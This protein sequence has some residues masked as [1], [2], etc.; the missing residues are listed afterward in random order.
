MPWVQHPLPG[1]HSVMAY[2]GTSPVNLGNHPRLNG[3]QTTGESE[4]NEYKKSLWISFN[5]KSTFILGL[6]MSTGRKPSS[7]SD[8]I[9]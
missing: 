4:Q 2:Q 5:A 6:E 1:P 7:V 3:D 8:D 9:V